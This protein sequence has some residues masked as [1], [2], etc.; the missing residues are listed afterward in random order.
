MNH[1]FSGVAGRLF[2][3]AVIG[4]ISTTSSFSQRPP[5]AES[6]AYRNA[7]AHQITM[8]ELTGEIVHTQMQ[9]PKVNVPEVLKLMRDFDEC[10][11]CA[12][13][14]TR[15]VFEKVDLALAQGGG[16]GTALLRDHY[17]LWRAAIDSFKPEIDESPRTYRTRVRDAK[18]I[19][20]NAWRRFFVE[21]GL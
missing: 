5:F 16:K 21:A 15:A 8:C 6:L 3:A 13:L 10:V 14:E 7:T 17:V 1:V 19:A 2:L 12:A 20:E 11:Q 9:F 4:L 18:Q